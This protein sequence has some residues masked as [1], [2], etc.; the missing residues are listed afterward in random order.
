[1]A[2]QQELDRSLMLELYRSALAMCSEVPA[3][4]KTVYTVENTLP[5][6]KLPDHVQ[7]LKEEAESLSELVCA[8]RSL[9]ELT[10]VLKAVVRAP[11]HRRARDQARGSE[12]GNF[13]PTQSANTAELERLRAANAIL[14]SQLEEE[15][16]ALKA[17]E[18]Q[19]FM[20]LGDNT[21][22]QE[23]ATAMS[24][25]YRRL[26]GALTS[27]NVI[28][29]WGRLVTAAGRREQLKE[30]EACKSSALAVA[31]RSK[32]MG[33]KAVEN[34]GSASARLWGKLAV[35]LVEHNKTAKLLSEVTEVTDLSSMLGVAVSQCVRGTVEMAQ[36]YITTKNSEQRLCGLIRQLSADLRDVMVKHNRLVNLIKTGNSGEVE[37]IKIRHVAPPQSMVTS[38]VNT[39][40]DI[41]VPED[42]KNEPPMGTITLS[43]TLLNN[44]HLYLSLASICNTKLSEENISDKESAL[45]VSNNLCMFLKRAFRGAAVERYILSM[46]EVIASSPDSALHVAKATMECM[47]TSSYLDTSGSHA[48]T[49]GIYGGVEVVF[50]YT[51]I[52][53]DFYRIGLSGD[54]QVLS[55]TG[56]SCSNTGVVWSPIT[57]SSFAKVIETVTFFRKCFTQ[58]FKVH[59]CGITAKHAKTNKRQRVKGLEEIQFD[60]RPGKYYKFDIPVDICTYVER[61]PPM[62]L[63]C[64]ETGFTSSID[65]KSAII[66][67]RSARTISKPSIN[68]DVLMVMCQAMPDSFLKCGFL[69]KDI[70]KPV[71]VLDTATVVS[72]IS[73]T[74]STHLTEDGMDRTCIRELIRSFATS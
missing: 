7:G 71:T 74:F 3:I 53:F 20:T 6:D 31:E 69:D 65:P 21:L 38:S 49:I 43:S 68:M 35:R 13:P 59:V 41:F 52:E 28:A 55:E 5:A 39:R 14:T 36:D 11:T 50:S 48:Y 66:I 54:I 12:G 56:I 37:Y 61:A 9:P 4:A 33:R 22:L 64:T 2:S 29:I 15:R 58:T 17:T 42:S 73:S 72:E 10:M 18:E 67:K 27:Q 46:E 23:R 63:G 70:P 1:M 57:L 62:A 45:E 51:G 25:A 8:M 47:L 34:M 24:G 40:F 44:M 60:N 26:R 19:L 32:N 16:K 30:I